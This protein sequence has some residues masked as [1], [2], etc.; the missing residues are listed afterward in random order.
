[1]KLRSRILF[2]AGLLAAA[3]AAGT[4]AFGQSVMRI[5]GLQPWRSANGDSDSTW[6]PERN[7]MSFSADGHFAVFAS[8]AGNLIPDDRNRYGDI[9]V[10]DVTIDAMLGVTSNASFTANGSSYDPA[11]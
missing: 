11:I 9:F 6:F 3:L 10:Y 7:E 5:T 2:F 1:M 4:P 8:A